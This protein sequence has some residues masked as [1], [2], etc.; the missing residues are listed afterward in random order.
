MMLASST[1]FSRE[2]LK[3]AYDE[4]ETVNGTDKARATLK[5]ATG[6]DNVEEVAEAKVI[7]G[8][9]A[10]VSSLTVGQRRHRA[11]GSR[12]GGRIGVIHA[13]LGDLAEKAFKR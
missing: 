3:L 11:S 1:T 13:R 2:N 10:L 8:V 4:F 6:A 5:A 12:R 9:A 7:V